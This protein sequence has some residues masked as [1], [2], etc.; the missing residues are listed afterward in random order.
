MENLSKKVFNSLHQNIRQWAQ[1]L[2]SQHGWT[3]LKQLLV[4]SGL[5]SS[6]ICNLHNVNDLRITSV[7]SYYH[8][9][10]IEMKIDQGHYFSM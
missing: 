3:S 9:F 10:S 8:A 1:L 7:E 6:A 4:S 5:Q 2:K